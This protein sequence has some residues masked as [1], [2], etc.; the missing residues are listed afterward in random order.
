LVEQRQK[1]RLVAAL[2]SESV[3]IV[4]NRKHFLQVRPFPKG[5]PVDFYLASGSKTN[6]DY[7]DGHEQVV[8]TRV[9]PVR[10]MMWRNKKVNM[11]ANWE[12]NLINYYGYEWRIPRKSKGVYPPKSRI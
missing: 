5:P 2:N 6:N 11:P 10:T 3:K 12:Q 8:W 4:K 7:R 9:Q 1:S